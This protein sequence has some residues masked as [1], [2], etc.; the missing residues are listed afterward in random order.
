M[1]K[2][3]WGILGA[4][5]L[6][7]NFANMSSDGVKPFIQQQAELGND[8]VEQAATNQNSLGK[9]IQANHDF[10]EN[11]MN[12]IPII[13]TSYAAINVTTQELAL[14]TEANFQL[15]Y[16][17]LQASSKNVN[18]SLNKLVKF[19]KAKYFPDSESLS[20]FFIDTIN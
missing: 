18:Q 11:L 7:D 20:T 10:T 3:F 9:V 5:N 8:V 14:K 19:L 6:V 12:T 16:T 17:I 15:V 13:A 2:W 4:Y 1:R